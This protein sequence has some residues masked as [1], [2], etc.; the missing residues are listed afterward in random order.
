MTGLL[1]SDLHSLEVQEHHTR[2]G[3]RGKTIHQ[4]RYSSEIPR[5]LLLSEGC[6]AH[7]ED[8][9]VRV[10]SYADAYDASIP[11]PPNNASMAPPGLPK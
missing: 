8:K 4:R 10:R 9:A 7:L 1:A 5:A 2:A 3:G 11:W 6:K